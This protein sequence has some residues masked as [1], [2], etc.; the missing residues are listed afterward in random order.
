VISAAFHSGLALAIAAVAARIGEA[1]V[2]LSGGCFQNARLTEA[3]IDAL[4]AIGLTPGWHERVPANDG[5]LALGQAW[6]AARMEGA[7]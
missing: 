4:R 7:A 1:T 3:T 5:G 2:V 6:W